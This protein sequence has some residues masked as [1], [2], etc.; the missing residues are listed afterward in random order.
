VKLDSLFWTHPGSKE[1]LISTITLRS[2][3]AAGVVPKIWARF[4]I[5]IA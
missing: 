4:F 5:V 1:S 2:D 3:R